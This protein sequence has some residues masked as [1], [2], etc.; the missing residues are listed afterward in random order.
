LQ[1]LANTATLV[2]TPAAFL[3]A[4]GGDTPAVA[5][6]KPAGDAKA[7][8]TKASAATMAPA[9]TKASAAEPTKAPASAGTPKMGGTLKIAIYQEPGNLNP[10]LNTQ[11][12]GSV[13]RNTIFN[14]LVRA[15]EKGEYVPDLAAEVPTTQ[16]GGVSADGKTVTFK[17]R[18]DV[19]WHDGKPFTAADVKFTFDVIM[20]AANP[21]TSRS[22]YRDIETFTVKDDATI[23][24]KFKNFYAPFVTIFG[25]I[26]PAHPFGGTTAIEK[27]D[28]NRKPIGTGPF[29]FIE[30]VSGDHIT[31]GK[32]PDFYVKGKPYLDQVIFRV[33]PS[34]EVGIAQLK[35]GE[36]DVVWNLIE[37]QIPEFD[38]NAEVDVWAKPGLGVERLILNL[39]SPTGDKV[40]DPSTK[41]PVLSDPKIRE[42]IDIG[43]NKKLIVDKLLYGKTTVGSSPLSSGWAAPKV[44]PSEYAPDKAKKLLDDAGWKPG[45]DGIRVKDGVKASLTYQTTSG[46]KLRELAQQVIQE[47]LK[48]IGIAL[49]IKNIP[50]ASL[51]GTWADNAPRAKGTFD[52]NMWTT[53]PGI[54][55]HAHM[56]IYFHSSQIPSEANKGE[57]QNYSRLRDA[58]IDKAL[59]EAGSVPDLEKRKAAY[60]RA[61][62][63]ITASRAHIFLYNRLDVDG[64]RK[65]VQGRTH[66]PWDNLGWDLHTWWLNK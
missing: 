65:Y 48:D 23:E 1:R 50:S 35:T 32:N 46:D 40:G 55:P 33:T 13:V 21:V 63:A 59:E 26:L 22:G 4:C 2:G 54:D 45:A 52:I 36:V 57:G 39:S 64:A 16:N 28:F 49:E 61:I 24:L 6:T 43:I 8:P 51:L 7:E 17:L 3:A 18:K 62:R 30:W 12:V 10:F 42:A 11:T 15:N 27:S 58:E 20:D 53:S 60:E 44:S 14:G 34:R 66:N 5:P 38:G 29:K 47:Q 41:H 25:A 9:P 56:F 19:K 37:A 31:V